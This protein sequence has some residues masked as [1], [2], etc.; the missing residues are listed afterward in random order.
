M[1]Q[2]G[3]HDAKRSPKF[4]TTAIV[5][6]ALLL[7]SSCSG[8]GKAPSTESGGAATGTGSRSDVT[9]GMSPTVFPN[10]AGIDFDRFPRDRQS[11]YAPGPGARTLRVRPGADS[12]GTGEY[13]SPI[14]ASRAAR[15]G[16][17]IYVADG[18]YALADDCD[19][20]LRLSTP[21]VTLAAENPGRVTF[22]PK[23]GETR[24][25]GIEMA[26]DDLFIDGFAVKGFGQAAV[27][28]G[29]EGGT[30]KNAVIKRIVIE[31]G[32]NGITALSS[33]S[34]RPL[35]RPLVSGLLIVDSV[36]TGTKSTEVGVDC[37]SG[38]CAD[39]RVSRLMVHLLPGTGDGSSG[40]DAF[41]IEGGDNVVVEASEMTGAPA[42]GVDLKSTRSAVVNTVVH[43]VRR[44]GVKLW[45]GGDVINTLVYNTGADASV[46]FE[47]PGRY[48]IIGSV[49]AR[50]ERGGEAYA[51]TVAYDRNGPGSLEIVNSIFFDNGGALWVAGQ[52]D[53]KIRN[54]IFYG[55]RSGQ[56]VNW[57]RSP[58][59]VADV[60]GGF[61]A[62]EAVGAATST[63]EA[64]PMFVDPAK[65][66][67]HM[68]SAGPAT[69][70]G[71]SNVDSFPPFDF[72]GK[73]RGGVPTIGI[74]QPATVN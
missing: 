19:C 17:V 52:T 24:S 63:R 36:V 1:K 53:L 43:D 62:L 51:A 58:E 39:V 16:D 55:S 40:A 46:V 25:S 67:F 74:Y 60:G 70:A 7:L 54:S 28:L 73:P 68:A 21:G 33:D 27:L 29:W 35:N 8:S 10:I 72:D 18:E 50:H 3:E 38:P 26:A 9:G 59:V 47:D 66:D 2:A 71:T 34:P 20:A 32:S 45:K 48:R 30:L 56:L 14:E 6:L 65:G 49:I 44:N 41:A 69:V 22:V 5:L 11:P 31:A 64:D 12:S 15:P 61:A 13:P 42:D 57:A 23:P 37:S 4:G